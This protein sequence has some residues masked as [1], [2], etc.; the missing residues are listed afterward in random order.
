[1]HVV[2]GKHGNLLCY[3]TSVELNI[4]P[5]IASVSSS[6]EILCNKYSDVFKGI[7]KLK[8]VKAKIH[9]DEN[10][11]P[12]IQP[13]RRIPFHIR[14][15]VEAELDRHEQLDSIDKVDGPTPWVSPIVVAPKRKILL[16]F[17][18]V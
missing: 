16:K 4:V 13:H 2:K 7:G 10:G 11:I 12:V 15:Q 6:S 8:D 5:I 3:D 17:V 14:K 9:V 18:C 1:M